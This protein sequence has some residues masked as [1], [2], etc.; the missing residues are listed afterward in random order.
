[1]AIQLKLTPQSV[2]IGRVY[3]QDGDPVENA[4]VQV[5]RYTY[6]RSGRQLSTVGTGTTNDLGEY[7]VAG[8]APG[9]YYVSA[10]GRGGLAG[11]LAGLIGGGGGAR[12]KQK[13]LFGGP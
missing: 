4:Q 8:L 13:G 3:D 12:G 11:R 9:R 10:T 6:P 5:M 2:I 7:R 1:S